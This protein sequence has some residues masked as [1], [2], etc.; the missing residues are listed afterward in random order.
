MAEL[1]KTPVSPSGE[2]TS[3]ADLQHFLEGYRAYVRGDG[4]VPSYSR[5]SP[6]HDSWLQG[7]QQAIEDTDYRRHG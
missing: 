3:N 5:G 6:Q 4:V 1:R 2:L 7:W